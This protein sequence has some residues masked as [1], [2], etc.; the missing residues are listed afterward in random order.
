MDWRYQTT[1]TSEF[2][3]ISRFFTIYRWGMNLNF[4]EII[5]RVTLTNFFEFHRFL[6]VSRWGMGL[7]LS[8][9]FMENITS[10]LSGFFTI[11]RW[12]MSF[13]KCINFIEIFY[14]VTLT[15]FVEFHRFWRFP[16]ELWGWT[17]YSNSWKIFQ[18][19]T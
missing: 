5:N 2:S 12:V 4:I 16:D 17:Y 9:K 3:R 6:T 11:Y 14:Q 13:K 19:S 15:N 7:N 18:K 10:H 1:H 8:L